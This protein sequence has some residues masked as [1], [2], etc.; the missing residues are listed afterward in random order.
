MRYGRVG[1]DKRPCI[2][3]VGKMIRSMM[4]AGLLVAAAAPAAAQPA[5]VAQV[6]PISGTRLDVVAAGEVNRVPDVVR[7][8][9]GVMT[10][11]PTASEAIR[12]NADQMRSM[13]AAL[14]RAGVAERDI[15]TSSLNLHPQWRHTENRLPEFSGYQAHNMVN[16][17]FRDIANA[18]RIIDALVEAGANQIDGPMFE[19]DE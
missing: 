9:A 7:I 11:A 13:R 12:Q 2:E 4:M 18:G 15:Q 10:Q 17:R 5:Q 1:R 3:G 6:V 19:I 16:V 8:N 14:Q